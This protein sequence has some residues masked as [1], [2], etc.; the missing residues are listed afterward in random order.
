MSQ[1]TGNM[2]V[3]TSAVTV[4]VK[5]VGYSKVD[6]SKSTPTILKQPDTCAASL[7]LASGSKK[8]TREGML[9]TQSSKNLDYNLVT[10]AFNGDSTD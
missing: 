4:E 9:Q 10:P 3:P 1:T 8:T 6:L 2:A 5:Q 7:A